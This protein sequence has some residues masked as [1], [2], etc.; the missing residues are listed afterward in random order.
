ME[1]RHDVLQRLMRGEL[2][3]VEGPRLESFDAAQLADAMQHE[4]ERCFQVGYT[5]ITISMSLQDA[6][7]MVRYLRGR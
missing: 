7:A 1:L 4:V 5:H 3:V 6:I 2:P